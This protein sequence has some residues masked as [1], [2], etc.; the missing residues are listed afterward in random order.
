MTSFVGIDL[1]LTGTGLAIFRP[2]GGERQYSHTLI[3]T[4]PKDYCD[5][6]RRY[7]FIGNEVLKFI[8][9]DEIGM[10]VVEDYILRAGNVLTTMAL[11]ELGAVV[12][13]ALA[14]SGQHWTTVVGSQLKKWITGSGAGSKGVIVKDVYKRLNIDVDD[15]NVADAIVLSRMAH[16]LYRFLAGEQEMEYSYRTEVIKKIAQTRER[17]NETA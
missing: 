6:W 5:R 10:I 8:R 2:D 15:D 7:R 1:S 9:D 17:F 3:R 11:I 4:T 14:E 12:R 16:D 13:M